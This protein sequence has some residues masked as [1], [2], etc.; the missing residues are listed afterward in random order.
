[1]AHGQALEVTNVLI[2]TADDLGTTGKDNLYGYGIVDAD[3]AALPPP[4]P[5]VVDQKNSRPTAL[6]IT[7]GTQI[8]GTTVS[9]LNINDG[10]YLTVKSAKLSIF[11]YATDWNTKTSISTNKPEQSY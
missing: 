3:Q 10:S 9:N 6:S 4:P 11:S 1:M 7:R 2:A 5:P 8:S